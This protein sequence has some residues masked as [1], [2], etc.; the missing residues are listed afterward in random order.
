MNATSNAPQGAPPAF[1]WKRACWPAAAGA[2]LVFAVALPGQEKQAEEEPVEYRNWVEVGVGGTFIDRGDGAQFMRRTQTPKGAYGGVLDFHLEQDVGK[3]AL[4]TIDGR[5]MFDHND[6][7]LAISLVEDNK[8]FLKFGYRQHRTFYDGSGG[9]LPSNGQWFELYDDEL[10]LDRGSVWFEGGLRLPEIPQFTVRYEYSWREGRKDSLVWGDTTLTPGASARGIVP[11]FWQ[12][13]EQRHSVSAD[14]R[15]TLGKTDLGLGF[16]YERLLLDNARKMRRS[17]GQAADRFLSQREQVT[18]DMFSFHATTETRFTDNLLFTT[19]YALTTLDT[20]I[21]GSRIYGAG[22]EA[23]FDPLFAGR[24]ARDEGFFGLGGGA[25]MRQ[26]LANLN[27]M[28]TPFEHLAVIPAVRIEKQD[29]DSQSTFTETVVGTGAGLPTALVPISTITDRGILDVSSGLEL[30]YTGLTNWVL[31]SRNDWMTGTGDLHETE[32]LLGPP[33]ATD[34]LRATGF[35]RFT[36][37]YAVGANWYPCRAFNLGAQYY[38]KN[39]QEDYNHVDDTTAN[40]SGNRYPAFL[41]KHEFDTDDVNFRVTLRPHAKV[42]LVSRYDFQQS[43]IFMQGDALAAQESADITSHIFNQSVSW[44]PWH[45]LNLQG[46]LTYARDRTETPAASQAATPIILNAENDYW[47]ATGTSLF[48]LDRRTDLQTQYTYYRADNYLDNSAASLPYGAGAEEHR[49]TAAL[50]RK[51]NQR[52]TWTL[53][54][55]FFDYRDQTS[56]GFNNFTAHLVFS[57]LRVQF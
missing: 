36:Q 42:T 52:M 29:L 4:L 49:I 14:V 45:R 17:P 27:L 21:G 10:K 43:K 25:Q 41:L 22:Y 1:G 11:S 18:S 51:I 20:D 57:S 8:G 16:R 46:T 24:Q 31:Y 19:G 37:K 3:K 2:I 44:T 53:K 33:A 55:G 38:H 32:T 6:H 13:D 39:R 12:L 26:Y 23:V 34:L 35:D 47:T 54:Y 30:R 5:G 28:W 56:G 50:I 9:F 7:A 40:R 15:H 48:V